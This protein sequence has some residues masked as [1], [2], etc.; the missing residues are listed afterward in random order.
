MNI[1]LQDFQS[2]INSE[3][4]NMLDYFKNETG[5]PPMLVC[6]HTSLFCLANVA[7]YFQMSDLSTP[8]ELSNF[9]AVG[10]PK[11]LKELEDTISKQYTYMN[12]EGSA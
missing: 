9:M 6:L 2:Q 8:P 7:G 5:V 12:T 4:L 1:P 3:V 11:I 10:Y